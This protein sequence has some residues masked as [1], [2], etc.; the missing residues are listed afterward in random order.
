MC[1]TEHGALGE[2]C[3]WNIYWIC[4]DRFSFSKDL[5]VTASFGCLWLVSSSAWGKGLTDIK[6]ATD[7]EVIVKLLD[8]CKDVQNICTPGSVSYMNRLNVSVVSFTQI[9]LFQIYH[10]FC[11]QHLG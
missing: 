7:P 6:L 5:V 9:R 1:S 8:V 3:P 4:T 2:A 10:N 11:V